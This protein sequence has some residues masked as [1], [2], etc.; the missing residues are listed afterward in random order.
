MCVICSAATGHSCGS[1]RGPHPL[2]PGRGEGQRPGGAGE[3]RRRGRGHNGAQRRG[4]P[5]LLPP[6]KGSQSHTPAGGGAGAGT[7]REG[8]G[9]G[10]AVGAPLILLTKQVWHSTPGGPWWTHCPQGLGEGGG[11]APPQWPPPLASWQQCPG[12]LVPAPPV[13]QVPAPAPGLTGGGEGWR[14]GRGP[15]GDGGGAGGAPGLL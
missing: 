12:R 8:G 6:P 7:V 9:S 2:P 5:R 15:R 10:P 4:L 13:A 3:G 1:L 14:R 11:G